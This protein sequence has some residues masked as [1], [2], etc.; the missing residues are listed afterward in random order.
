MKL[1]TVQY[2]KKQYVAR[3][4]QDTAF[5]YRTSHDQLPSMLD[6]IANKAQ[7]LDQIRTLSA[8]DSVACKDLEFLAPIPRPTSNIMCLGLNYMKHVHESTKIMGRTVNAPEFPIVFT[9]AASTVNKPDGNILLDKSLTQKLDW[10]VELAIIIGKNGKNIKPKDA[11]QYVF[12]YTIINDITARDLQRQHKQFFIGKSLD[13]A[14]PMGPVIVTSDEITNPHNLSISSKV[15]NEIQQSANTSQMMFKI[16]DII[17]ILS[18][19]RTLE[20]GDVIAT[21]TPSGVGVAQ[22]PPRF[23]QVGDEIKCEI[24]HIGQLKNYIKSA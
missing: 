8:S 19:S 23:L 3:I 2:N 1:A 17:A 4:E 12:G 22:D 11:M 7:H 5:I 15:N 18:R 14:C 10:E 20:A 16:P 13:G 9:K 21:G 6:V 24:E